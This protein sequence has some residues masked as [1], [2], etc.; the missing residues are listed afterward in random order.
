MVYVFFKG[1]FSKW[2]KQNDAKCE[3]FRQ[4]HRRSFSKDDEP[5]MT[6]TK[7]KYI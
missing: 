5:F 2:Q 7:E 4:T 6:K 3:I 1:Y